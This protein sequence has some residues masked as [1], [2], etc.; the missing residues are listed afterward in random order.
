[1]VTVSSARRF[2]EAFSAAVHDVKLENVGY[3][4]YHHFDSD[5]LIRMIFGYRDTINRALIERTKHSRSGGDPAQRLLMGA[6]ISQ[7]V[8]APPLMR[9]LLPHLYEVR[10]SVEGPRA[11]DSPEREHHT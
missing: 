11:H 3:E 2:L 7:R 10:R 9:A 1:M 8:G 5:F 6:L 4:I